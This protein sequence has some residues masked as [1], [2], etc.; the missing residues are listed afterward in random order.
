MAQRKVLSDGPQNQPQPIGKR[1]V[2]RFD[3]QPLGRSV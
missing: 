1:S 3:G 2:G